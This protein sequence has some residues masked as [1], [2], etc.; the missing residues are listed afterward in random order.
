MI[1]PGQVIAYQLR[2]LIRIL[3]LPTFQH[4]LGEVPT[5]GASFQSQEELLGGGGTVDERAS[6]ETIEALDVITVTRFLVGDYG[7]NL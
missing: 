3:A 5:V 4:A 2:F 7:E 6:I 1:H